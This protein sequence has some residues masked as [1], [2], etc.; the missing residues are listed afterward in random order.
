MSFGNK[1]MPSIECI[2]IIGQCYANSR[3]VCNSASVWK[4]RSGDFLSALC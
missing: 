4:D 2:V 3:Y 1:V